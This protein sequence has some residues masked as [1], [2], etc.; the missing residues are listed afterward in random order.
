MEV[1]GGLHLA[2]N[3]AGISPKADGGARLTTLTTAM[4]VWRKVFEVN[5]FSTIWLAQGL[6]DALAKAHGAIVNVTS[7]AG[8]RV[9]RRACVRR[10]R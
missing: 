1:F 7:I 3:N 5:L 8:S 2:V 9:H 6:R 4:E 10:L